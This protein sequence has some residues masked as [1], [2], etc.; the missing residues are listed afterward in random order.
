MKTFTLVAALTLSTAAHA[1]HINTKS[2][3]LLGIYATPKYG[4]MRVSSTIPG[5]SAEGVL[6]TG[7]V[8]LRTTVNG[9][10]FYQL[11]THY[12]MENAKIAI[13]PNQLAAV[14]FFRPGVGLMYAWVEFTPI[15]GPALYNKHSVSSRAMP[16]TQPQYKAQFKIDKNA[17]RMFSKQGMSNNRLNSRGAGNR[18]FK[19]GGVGNG[20][21]QTDRLRPGTTGAAALFNR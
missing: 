1:G 5:Y 8:L 7:D 10:E 13:G 2:G 12:E 20:R 18:G 11:R 16:K 9:Q 6:F 15:S 21:L 14:E 17:S 3:L 19:P 4:G